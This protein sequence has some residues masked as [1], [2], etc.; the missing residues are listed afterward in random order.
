MPGELTTREIASTARLLVQ[1]RLALE[2]AGALEDGQRRLVATDRSGTKRTIEVY[3]NRAPKPAGG[4][5][6]PALAWML[7]GEATT[8]LI[9]VADLSSDRAWLFGREEAY[10]LAQQHPQSGGHHLIMVTDPGLTDSKHE[11]ILD[12]DF[13]DHL[14]HRKA[15]EL[16]YGGQSGRAD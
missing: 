12:S 9:A 14:L 11:R 13:A 3:G 1:Y 16:F 4:K 15:A 7:D 2:G 10:R 5:G 6:R 8:D